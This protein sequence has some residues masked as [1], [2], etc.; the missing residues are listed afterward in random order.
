MPL[1][2]TDFLQ[3]EMHYQLNYQ[4]DRLG[5]GFYTRTEKAIKD[6]R[7]DNY[8]YSRK[9]GIF[10][11]WEL[12]IENAEE[13]CI[14]NVKKVQKIL[15]HKWYPYVHM[16][17]IFS[18]SCEDYKQSCEKV[19][20][21]LKEKNEIRFTYKQFDINI[22]YDEFLQIEKSFKKNTKQAEQKYG[23]RL[24]IHIGK[25]VRQSIEMFTGR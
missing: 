6:V 8:A 12:E 3:K 10:F 11:I 20:N 16:F 5:I 18:P 7:F 2:L 24:R 14:N 17:H 13:V 23:K 9:R 4:L 19:A 25:I 15:S 21:K 22:P 1:E